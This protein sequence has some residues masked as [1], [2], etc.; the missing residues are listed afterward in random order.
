[1]RVKHDC[2]WEKK[3]KEKSSPTEMQ[4]VGCRIEGEGLRV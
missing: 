3:Y 2:A 4:R 1:M